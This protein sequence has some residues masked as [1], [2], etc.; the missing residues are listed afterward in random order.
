MKEIFKMSSFVCGEKTFNI[1]YN[2]LN[3]YV[4]NNS[5]TFNQI[6]EEMAQG[7]FS[8]FSAEEITGL[9]Y[10]LNQ[11]ATG[12]RYDEEINLIDLNTDDFKIENVDIAL[13]YRCLC[14]LHYQSSE[15]LKIKSFNHVFK[16]LE[17]IKNFIAGKIAFEAGEKFDI[18]GE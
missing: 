17:M 8:A 13:F 7:G 3:K 15:D 10:K 5:F 16:A 2:G 9:F 4:V 12:S 14:C 18:W 6:N 1:I 11:V